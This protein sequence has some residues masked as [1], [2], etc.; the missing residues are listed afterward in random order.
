MDFIRSRVCGADVGLADTISRD[1]W[2]QV[3]RQDCGGAR[4]CGWRG[5]T[6]ETVFIT[7]EGVERSPKVEQ[8]E[9][10][11]R[12]QGTKSSR[13]RSVCHRG[14]VPRRQGLSDLYSQSRNGVLTHP[15]TDKEVEKH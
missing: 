12:T 6:P 8:C 7:L 4:G 5:C 1:T 14:R 15:K 2:V 9:F 10:F 3:G 13:S 11:V